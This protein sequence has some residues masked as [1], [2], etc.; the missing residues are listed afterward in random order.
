MGF[1]CLLLFGCQAS[2]YKHSVSSGGTVQAD[3]RISLLGGEHFGTW[4]TFDL[5]IPYRYARNQDRLEL[6]GEVDFSN[7]IKFNFQIMESFF[8]TVM[9]L[10]DQGTVLQNVDVGSSFYFADSDDP[11]KFAK[12]FVVPPGTTAMAFSYTGT[13]RG[14]GSNGDTNTDFWDF[15]TQ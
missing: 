7:R 15:P 2:V 6:S 8:V 5:T 1:V 13:A 14:I 12:T 10:N 3:K 11:I 4:K 9:L